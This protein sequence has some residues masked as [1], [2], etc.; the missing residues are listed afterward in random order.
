MDLAFA[1]GYGPAKL[2]TFDGRAPL[3]RAEDTVLFGF[4]D[5]EEQRAY[6][7]RQPP[8]E[9]R[10]FDFAS[11]RR[12]GIADAARAAVDHLARL[13]GFFIHLDADVLDDAIMPAVDYRLPDGFTW[14]ELAT[15]LA[16][17]L[18]SERAL[19]IELT[20]YNPALDRD[21]AAGRALADVVV[22]ALTQTA[23]APRSGRPRGR[24]RAAHAA[25]RQALRAGGGG[26]R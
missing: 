16:T 19:G 20:I 6:G 8:P 13:P 24:S 21:G 12:T 10:S 4:R 11:I 22:G 5:A 17:A 14:D 25:R 18:A 15:V 9:L 2:T 3:V 23:T 1:T 26:R 7:S